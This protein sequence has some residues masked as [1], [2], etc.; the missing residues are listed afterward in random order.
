MRPSAHAIFV[1]VASLVVGAAVVAGVWVV[2]GPGG[3]RLR[4]FDEARLQSLQRLSAAVDSHYAA[5]GALPEGLSEVVGASGDLTPQAIQDPESGAEFHYQRQD[6]SHYRLCA[7]FARPSDE[8]TPVRWRHGPG[9]A[10]F[11]LDVA[12]PAR[13]AAKRD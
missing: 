13:S 9:Y 7:T 8:E 12:Q 2:G 10:C 3:A 5:R 4:K 6:A 1:A 11:D